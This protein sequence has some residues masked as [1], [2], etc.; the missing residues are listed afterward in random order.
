MV[1]AGET[2]EDLYA[3]PPDARGEAP[4]RVHLLG[5]H[6]DEDGGWVLPCAIPARTVVE[7]AHRDDD[8]V[9]VATTSSPDGHARLNYRIGDEGP[10]GTWLDHVMGV[11]TALRAEALPVPGMSLRIEGDVPLGAGLASSASLVVAILRAVR[12]LT[13]AAV[14]D[15]GL[16]RLAH[17]AEH[18]F[19]GAPVGVVDPMACALAGD[20]EALLL[21]T[22]TLAFERIALP[23]AADIVV[24]DAG[25]S[26]HR[27]DGDH[28]T[29]RAECALAARTLGV[30]QL[31]DLDVAELG[32]LADL[33][34]PLGRRARHVVTENARVRAAADA[35]R[36]GDVPALG[37]LFRES[38]RSLRD[39]LQVSAL[40]IDA[41]VE[42]ADA[43]PGCHGSRL[44]GA[45]LGGAI[46][47]LVD[48]GA[49]S[50][51]ARAVVEAAAGGGAV[52]ARALLPAPAVA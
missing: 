47:A 26:H 9:E 29:R 39:D 34:E 18:D 8:V 23:D 28:A 49:A 24:I 44:T 27:A 11:T 25:L 1:L 4:G 33:P 21:D 46:V 22:R 19:V 48:R 5:D 16:A 43:Q 31:R 51:V 15:V 20:H 10:C 45:A 37:R 17:V 12:A 35:L 7:I 3:R 40:A 38:H 42:C 14:D 36:V 13:G 32:R 52:G 6:T 50:S 41:L 2:F 30:A